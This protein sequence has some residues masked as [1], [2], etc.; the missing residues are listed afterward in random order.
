[1]VQ[2]RACKAP[3]AGSIPAATSTQG[4]KHVSNPN[5]RYAVRETE[6]GLCP[7]GH[8]AVI[9]FGVLRNNGRVIERKRLGGNCPVCGVLSAE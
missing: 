5:N 4:R 2:A 1:V 9:R 8:R 6:R 7:L 3:Y